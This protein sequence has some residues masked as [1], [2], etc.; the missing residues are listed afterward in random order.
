MGSF[1]QFIQK[2]Q[3]MTEEERSRVI[4][5]KKSICIC[6]QCNIYNDCAKSTNELSYCLIGKSPKCIQPGDAWC[7]C[8]IC[9]ISEELGLKNSTFCLEDSEARQRGL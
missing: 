5:S 3:Q 2:L 4:D 1:E 8:R 6:S 9:P 7:V